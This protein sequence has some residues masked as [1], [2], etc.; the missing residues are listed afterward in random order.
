MLGLL[1]GGPARRPLAA[2]GTRRRPP[3]RRP[4]RRCRCRHRD[5]D[6]AAR[7]ARRVAARACRRRRGPPWSPS[8]PWA[9]TSTRTTSATATRSTLP[10]T[11]RLSEHPGSELAAGLGSAY[12]WARGI[13]DEEIGLGGTTAA[14]FQYGLYGPDSSNRVRYIGERGER[15]SFDE[16]ADCRSWRT[17]INDGGYRFVVTSP[18]YD[19]DVP[20][21]PLPSPTT[22]W[23]RSDSAAVQVL[24]EGDVTVFRID[25]E[26]D[27]STCPA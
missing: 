25:R 27:P 2:G 7:L 20:D 16:I 10:T 15:G 4:G 8:P 9:G 22:E 5:R 17:A 13:R 1:R 21:E 26:L 24:E 19:Q 12:E 18:G 23:T 11:R 3:R 14:F 6:R